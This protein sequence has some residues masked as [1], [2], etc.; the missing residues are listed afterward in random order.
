MYLL[1]RWL[2]NA[3]ALLIVAYIIPGVAVTSFAGALIAALALGIV[4]AIIRPILILLTLPL[5]ILTLGLFTFV[6]NAALFWWVGHLG[7]GLVVAGFWP[8]LWGAIVL[9]IISFLI[10]RLLAAARS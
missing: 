7:I 6:I 9:S 3:V 5:E 4:N 1:I 10:A 8:A 2:L